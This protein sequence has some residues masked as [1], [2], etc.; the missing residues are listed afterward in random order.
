MTEDSFINRLMLGLQEAIQPLTDALASP[1]EFRT[2]LAE[3][4]WKLDPAANLSSLETA[5]GS[6]GGKLNGLATASPTD[7][8]ALIPKLLKGIKQLEDTVAAGAYPFNQPEFWKTAD[9]VSP[10]QSF[11]IQVFDYLLITYLQ[12]HVTG[13]YGILLFT[14]IFIE[15]EMPETP[16]ADT[17]VPARSKYIR[18]SVDWENLP[19][20]IKDPPA[21]ILE[22]YAWDSDT[23]FNHKKFLNNLSGL[24]SFLLAVS[25]SDPITPELQ[26]L[27]FDIDSEDA[28]TDLDRLIFVPAITSDNED[29]F[30]LPV[31]L[32]IVAMPIPDEG[33]TSGDPVG[34]ALMPVIGG[35]GATEFVFNTY[36]TLGISGDFSIIPVQVEFRPSGVQLSQISLASLAEQTRIDTSATLQIE[37]PKDSP[38]ILFGSSSSSRLE[39]QK[40][41]AAIKVQGPV[42]DIEYVLEVVADRAQVVIDFSTSDGFLQNSVSKDA[43]KIDVPIG[44]SWSSKNG[45]AF[46]SC[47]SVFEASIPVHFTLLNTLT[48]HVITVS[49]KSSDDDGASL[50][51]SASISLTIGSLAAVVENVGMNVSFIDKPGEGNL[52]DN[53]VG[54]GF[55]PPNGVGLAID[56]GTVKG[57]GYLFFDPDREEYAG[58]LELVFSEWIA[59]K[60][61]GLITTKMPDGSKGFSMVI[62][63]TVEFGS[64]IQLGF[65][66]TLLGVGGLLG[67]HRT[68]NVEPLKEGV[69]TGAVNSVMFPQ[70]I[71]ENAPRIIS[72]LRRFFPPH[73]DIFL[74]GPMAKIGW[75]TP[76]LLSLSMG[77]IIEF[78][79]VNITIL[80]VLKVVLPDEKADILRIQVNFIGRIEPSNKLLWFYAELFDSRV[81]FITLEG[82]M[83]LLVN[84]GDNA[85][86]VVSVGGFHPQYSPPPLPFP[87]PQRISANILNESYA[88]IRIEGYFAVTSNSVQF[89]ARAE[90]YFGLSEFSIEG[91]LVFDALFQFDPFFFSFALSIE[92]SVKVF[93]IGVWSVG[94]SGILEGPTPWHIKGKGKISLFLFSKSVPF[95]HTWGGSRDTKLD[96]IEVFPLLEKEFNALTNWEAVLPNS[97]NILV[98]LRKLGEADTDQL[99]LHPV[100]KLRISQ[101]KIP[102]DFRLDK[103]GNQ[104]SS[105]VNRLYVNAAIPGGG[106]L[107]IS[108]RQEKFA[109]GQFKDLDDAG[110]LSSP[111]FEPLES[112][113][114]IA[115]AGEQ[116]KT[117]QAVKRSI[118][119]ETIIIDNNFKRHVKPFFAFFAK[120]FIQLNSFLFGHFL[121]GNAVTKSVLSKHHKNRI[122]PFE[123]VIQ[124]QPNQYSVVFNS[125]NRPFGA[126]DATF[127]SQAKAT[128]YLRQ[129]VQSD[130][131]LENDLDVIP[132][133]EVN[134]AA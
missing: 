41:H 105:D 115:V 107:S 32:S 98:S 133:S 18:K 91:H 52:G 97:S 40:G 43:T 48:V 80:G 70:N 72:D 61:I 66:F 10:V 50:T 123:E 113:V 51:L 23:P 65:G 6:V 100:G 67:L 132:N 83:G 79:N 9:G 71:V 127:T 126:D 95:E 84:W 60:A 76:P 49:L 129:Q 108:E 33:E 34:F 69:R 93:G 13:L 8:A 25:K 56:A 111:A 90:L 64:G 96:P 7:L 101:R 131:N 114:E 12:E 4:G 121:S 42:S 36:S 11:P 94:F 120:G 5:F 14:G 27:Y 73:A 54:F 81:L 104:R 62:I 24:A 82:G 37:L 45:F 44:F 106:S 134:L 30:A 22:S 15:D 124:I 55:K 59:L 88:R 102:L 74:V 112:G 35:H 86:F 116:M 57:G 119:Y 46:S 103:V 21:S 28:P 3:F 38:W 47:S 16:L 117:S 31:K 77:V 68:A 99:V 29:I 125:N 53:E 2:F 85:N 19:N 63:I 1:E 17:T 26:A 109:I 87:E 75:G 89:G 92:L 39:L 118:R 110:R 20:F 78:P 128:E 58:A 122:Q 130:P